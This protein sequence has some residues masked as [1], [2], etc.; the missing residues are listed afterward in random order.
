M[1]N[2]FDRMLARINDQSDITLG[3]DQN[4]YSDVLRLH[5]ARLISC[6][7]TKTLVRMIYRKMIHSLV[8]KAD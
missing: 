7:E 4:L 5:R 8:K 1:P 3:E 2:A 6:A